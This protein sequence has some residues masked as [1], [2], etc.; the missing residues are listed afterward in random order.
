MK[1]VIYEGYGPPEVLK[2]TE[3]PKPTPREQEVLIRIHATTV[4]AGDWRMRRPDPQAARLY[5]GL[6]RPRKVNILGF[7]LAGVVEGLGSGVTRYR[8]G[9]AVFGEAGLKFGAYAQYIC[10][11]EEGSERAGLLAPKPETIPF[12]EAAAV[13]T[14]GL[15]ALNHLKK[16]EITPGQ[17][18]LIIGASGS[19]G[20]F[21]VQLAKYFGAEVTGI[22]GPR[23]R[24]LVRS[25]GAAEVIDYTREDFRDSQQR[26]DL[27]FD[28]AGKRI[29]GITKKS[30]KKAISPGGI[31]L[32]VEMN[33]KDHPE[34]LVF[35]KNLIDDGELKP[36]VDREYPLQEIVEAHR[37][38]ESGQKR[39]SVVIRV[40]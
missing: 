30:V 12:C 25:F 20:S 17:K 24:D 3:V 18:V 4:T 23:N 36:V 19:V 6:L 40:P 1:A 32:S 21:A 7:E 10:L 35:L 31:F 27:V 13:P 38:V 8:V 15:A 16:G 22:C 39:G 37:Y 29:S 14:G 28:A 11:P 33:R 2:L 9:D 5:N 26:Y 34:D